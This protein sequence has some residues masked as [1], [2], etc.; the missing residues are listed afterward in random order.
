MR[1]Q[2]AD[3]ELEQ[4]CA[5]PSAGSAV[6]QPPRAMAGAEAVTLGIVCFPQSSLA[7]TW[8]PRRLQLSHHHWSQ[9]GQHFTGGEAALL[10]F[11]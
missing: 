3:G 6:L 5:L 1:L 9:L 8:M 7:V 10:H 4:G 2:T 11:R